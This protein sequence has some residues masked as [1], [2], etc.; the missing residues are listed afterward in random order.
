MRY[1]WL[2][3]PVLR[4]SD[5]RRC[6][7]EV[8]PAHRHRFESEDYYILDGVRIDYDIPA[9]V[10]RIVRGEPCD[11]TPRPHMRTLYFKVGFDSYIP[12]HEFYAQFVGTTE[13]QLQETALKAAGEQPLP[14]AME[15]VA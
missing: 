3:R 5:G 4:R 8:D 10:S 7:R 14:E 2:T 1:V 9:L 13:A 11:F 6:E 15:D 12:N